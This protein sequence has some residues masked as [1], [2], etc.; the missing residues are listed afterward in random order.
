MA[1]NKKYRSADD[2]P[3]WETVKRLPTFQAKVEYTWE[4]WRVHI[5]GVVF[6]IVLV[7]SLAITNIVNNIPSYLTGG[8][9]NILSVSDS[10]RYQT[11][12]LDQV[13]LYDKL[14]FTEEDNITMRCVT[15]LPLDL[16]GQSDNSELT[17]NSIT[18][19]DG[20]LPSNEFDYFLMTENLVEW[21]YKRYGTPLMDLRE[22]LTPAELT[23][24]ADRLRYTNS[25]IPVAIDVSD[26]PLLAE[27]YLTADKPVCFAWFNYTKQTDRMRPFFDFLM[28]TLP[29]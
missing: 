5:L 23:K 6:L 26:S 28:S 2:H 11:E 1:T 27:M 17:N 24:Y 15:G 22:F 21:L 7:S 4:N 8:Y 29:Q 16:T 20:M 14:G 3:Y 9:L 25:G 18:R 19:L 13:F 10:S 12:Y